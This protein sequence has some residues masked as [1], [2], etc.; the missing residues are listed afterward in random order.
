MD[1]SEGK[2][3]LKSRAIH[4]D[5]LTESDERCRE[6]EVSRVVFPVNKGKFYAGFYK[7]LAKNPK[8]SRPLHLLQ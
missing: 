8:G 7:G 6:L 2:R 5:S 4:P 3:G 1:T